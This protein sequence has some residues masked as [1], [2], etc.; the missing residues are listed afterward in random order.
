[1][2]VRNAMSRSVRA[3]TPGTKIMEVASLMCLYRFH[4]LPVVDDRGRCLG[5]L[6]TFKISHYLFPPREEA[7]SARMVGAC[8]RLISSSS[9]QTR[10]TG[11]RSSYRKKS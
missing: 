3:V 11:M 7:A 8:R 5:L 10:Y 2:I 9:R 6:S 1:M 4:G